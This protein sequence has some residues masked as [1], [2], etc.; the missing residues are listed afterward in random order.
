MP[1]IRGGARVIATTT[2]PQGPLGQLVSDAR[3]K[4]FNLPCWTP[5]VGAPT[6]SAS[7][8]AIVLRELL[9]HLKF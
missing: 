6:S 9:L 1:A 3:C 4:M 2:A 7:A 8:V 5:G